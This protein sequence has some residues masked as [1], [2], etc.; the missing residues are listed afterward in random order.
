M[1]A[2]GEQSLVVAPPTLDELSKGGTQG[3]SSNTGETRPV[4][5]LAPWAR[6]VTALSRITY[7]AYLGGSFVLIN[8]SVHLH[9][10]GMLSFPP[11]VLSLMHRAGAYRGNFTTSQRPLR[12]QA[13]HQYWVPSMAAK[14]E[15]PCHKM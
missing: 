1:V 5:G 15:T 7:Y 8:G 10:A 11:L 9:H 6:A 12:K 3:G 4:V 2:F 13:W 14:R